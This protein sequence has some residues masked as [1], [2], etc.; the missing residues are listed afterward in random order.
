MDL[1]AVKELA[2]LMQEMGLTS[3]EVEQSGQHIV[4]K[5]EVQVAA[6]APV[7][8]AAPLAAPMVAPPQ[9]AAPV[10]GPDEQVVDFN[11]ITEIKSPMVGTVY[12]AAS[13]EAEPYVKAGDKV[14]KGQVLC[15][16]EA[17]KLMNEFTAPQDGEIVDICVKDGQLV[18]Y[19]QCLFKVF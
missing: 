13:P 7:M 14:K 2:R 8:P 18:E 10:P 11:N 3:L 9:P 6:A 12:M 17:M 19:G 15:V 4:L 16:I 5:K 1:Q